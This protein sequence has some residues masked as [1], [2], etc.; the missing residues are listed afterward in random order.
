M[1]RRRDYTS[2]EYYYC[3]QLRRKR[4]KTPEQ[5]KRLTQ[6]DKDEE[7]NRRNPKAALL[8]VDRV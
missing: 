5:I 4:S 1:L 2:L 8:Q 3:E 7:E 6:H